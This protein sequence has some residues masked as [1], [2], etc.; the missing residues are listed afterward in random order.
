MSSLTE[1]GDDDCGR[2]DFELRIGEHNLLFI[3]R[4]ET[5]IPQ[6]LRPMLSCAACLIS[7]AIVP[8]EVSRS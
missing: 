8:C 2:A 7:L 1:S 3:S 6:R 5:R 4:S